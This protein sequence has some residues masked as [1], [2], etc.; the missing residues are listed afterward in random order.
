MSPGHLLFSLITVCKGDALDLVLKRKLEKAVV[1]AVLGW[2]EDVAI[3]SS[4]KWFPMGAD[5]IVE[6]LWDLWLRLLD[7]VESPNQV[8]EL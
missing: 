4:S 3:A 2:E 6:G 7:S 5:K 1:D 8:V